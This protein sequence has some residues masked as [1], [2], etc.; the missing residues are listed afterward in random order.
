M[1]ANSRYLVALAAVDDPTKAKRDP[2][3]NRPSYLPVGYQPS[4]CFAPGGEPRV[5]LQRQSISQTGV[6]TIHAANF[7]TPDPVRY[8]SPSLGNQCDPKP[9]KWSQL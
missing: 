6:L 2:D 3:R 5:R 4:C 9:G 7:R 1:Q 8:I